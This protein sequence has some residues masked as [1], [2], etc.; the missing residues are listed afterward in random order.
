[1]GPEERLRRLVASSSQGHDCKGYPGRE[2]GTV[3]HHK[4]ASRRFHSRPLCAERCPGEAVVEC[5]D[6]RPVVMLVCGRV[7]R[8]PLLEGGRSSRTLVVR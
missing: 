4:R 2:G 1:M 8:Y 7:P 6:V 5:E 3:V